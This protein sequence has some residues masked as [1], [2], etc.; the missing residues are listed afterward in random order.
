[1]NGICVVFIKKVWIKK[2]CC[3]FC[4]FLLFFD[5]CLFLVIFGCLW[6]RCVVD[7]V[8][9]FVIRII[10]L[11]A[12]LVTIDTIPCFSI[13]S[14]A[15]VMFPGIVNNTNSAMKATEYELLFHVVC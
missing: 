15:F 14:D 12:M 7:V 6:L 9:V 11:R 2:G 10:V 13:L 8:V 4:Y 5:F 1:M 3:F